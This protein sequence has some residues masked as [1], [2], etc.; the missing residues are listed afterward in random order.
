MNNVD[1]NYGSKKKEHLVYVVTF[2]MGKGPKGTR[3]NSCL[4]IVILNKQQQQQQQQLQL[5]QQQHRQQQQQK[6]QQLQ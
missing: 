1:L 3:F 6:Q 5:Q 2:E 4:G